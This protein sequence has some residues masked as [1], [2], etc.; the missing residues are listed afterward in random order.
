[1]APKIMQVTAK[2]LHFVCSERKHGAGVGSSSKYC[3]QSLEPQIRQASAELGLTSF[4]S[5]PLK[6][7]VETIPTLQ[8]SA[9]TSG[10]FAFL[11][12]VSA[13]IL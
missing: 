9:G 10:F 11:K 1:M 12:L 5:R 3:D 2:T 7:A 8:P 6:E 4:F 13:Q